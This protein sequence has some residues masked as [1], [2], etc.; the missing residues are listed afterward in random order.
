AKG[1]SAIHSIGLIH[2][3]IRPENILVESDDTIRIGGFAH[4]YVHPGNKHSLDHLRSDE[5]VGTW[6]YIAPEVMELGF[7]R[8]L[9][10]ALAD[11][12]TAAVDYWSLG[13]IVFELEATGRKR[14]PMFSRYSDVE[15]Y[16]TYEVGGKPYPL[17]EGMSGEAQSLIFALVCVDPVSRIGS[18]D[19]R[20][21]PYFKSGSG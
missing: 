13:C 14:N 6:P 11:S 9:Q 10:K 5:F 2:R 1:I 4:T 20:H 17:F 18:A 16:A 21:H 3:D 8:K 7:E 12:Y 15:E 19:L